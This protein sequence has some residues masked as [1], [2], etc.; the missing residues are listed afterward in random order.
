MSR[1]VVVTGIGVVSAYGIG[2]QTFWDGL[3][4]GR[5]QLRKV[6]AFA[7]EGFRSELAFPVPDDVGTLAEQLSKDRA[8]GFALIAIQEALKMAAYEEGFQ[9]SSRVGCVL[10]SLCAGIESLI[11][12]AENY[13]AGQEAPAGFSAA[14][15]QVNNQLLELAEKYDICGPLS[16]VST[17]CASTTDAV[18]YGADLIRQDRCDVMVVGGGDTLS[19][20]IHA[21]FN[22]LFSITTTEPK[23]F[24]SRRDGFAIGEG[25]GILILEELEHARNRG[26]HAIAEIKGYGL[27]NTAFH[28]TATSDDGKGEALAISRALKDAGL[29]AKDIDYINTHGTGTRHNDQSELRAVGHIFPDSAARVLANSIKPAIG[30]CMGAAGILEAISTVLA[31]KNEAVPPTL[32]TSGDEAVGILD[33]VIGSPRASRIRHA[34]SQ[35]FGFGGA[36]SCLVVSDIH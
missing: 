1:R 32:F 28:L 25:A 6:D 27:S 24:D 18:G 5:S 30:H 9:G 13:H 29:E 2:V 17:A 23:P 19:S 4:G 26:V 20:L 21:G 34:L 10:G 15:A 14:A 3:M 16:M 22:S 31:I 8:T 35:S 11:S 12:L 33:L 7:S 36:C